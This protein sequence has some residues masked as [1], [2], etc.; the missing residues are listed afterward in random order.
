M[1]CVAGSPVPG[2][3]VAATDAGQSEPYAA[4]M[5]IIRFPDPESEKRG[6]GC[7]IGRFSFKS[8]ANGQTVVPDEA[9]GFLARGG[10][11][12]SVEGPATYE[13]IAPLRNPPATAVQ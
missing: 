10:F 6:L 4:G 9:P 2:R 7:L 5:T 11:H 1:L 3:K 8:W 13:K 12:F